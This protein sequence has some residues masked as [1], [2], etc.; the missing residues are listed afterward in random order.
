ML[1]FDLYYE[2]TR[3]KL[4][5]KY[6]ICLFNEFNSFVNSWWFLILNELSRIKLIYTLLLNEEIKHANGNIVASVGN[7]TKNV[8]LWASQDYEVL[9][10]ISKV[11]GKTVKCWDLKNF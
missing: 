1:I 6:Y 7:S 4:N 11:F 5:W 10:L 9:E 8:R 3:C 2:F